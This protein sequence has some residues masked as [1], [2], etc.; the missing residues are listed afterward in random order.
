[1]KRY[2]AVGTNPRPVGVGLLRVQHKDGR[3]HRKVLSQ[4][5]IQRLTMIHARPLQ[6]TASQE[7]KKEQHTKETRKENKK[8]QATGQTNR[9]EKTNK[10]KKKRR[11]RGKIKKHVSRG[12]LL[13]TKGPMLVHKECL[14]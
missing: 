8:K 13:D 12:R 6:E 10:T 7:T 11:Q 14:P 2:V 4:R 3:S 9:S 1:M 5:A